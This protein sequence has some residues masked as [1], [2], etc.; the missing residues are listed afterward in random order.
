MKL[1]YLANARIPTEKAHGYQICKMCEEF[2]SLGNQVELW[3]PARKNDIY[4]DA[5]SFYGLKNNFKVKEINS[6]DF[7]KHYK[8]L[9]RLSFWLQLFCFSLKLLFIKIDRQAVIYTRDSEIGW[10]FNLKGNKVILE[11][12]NWPLSKGWLFKYLI[13]KFDKIITITRGLK[14][15]FLAA[16]LP[17]SRIMVAPD[18][19]D[20]EKFNVNINKIQARKKL[21][22]PLNKKIALYCGSLYL[23]SWKGVDILLAAAKIFPE[24]YLVVLVGGEP[25]ELAKIKKESNGN[26]LLLVG[27][28]PREEIPY[29]LKSADVL[30]LPNS[31]KEKISSSYTSPLKLFEYMA[32]QRPIV[33]S[34]LPSIREILNENNS[35][36]VE[37]G[38]TKSLADGIKKV[39]SDKEL[40]DK[41]SR[42]AYQDVQRYVWEKRAKN[43]INYIK[44]D[45]V[46]NL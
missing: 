12:H 33:A 10:I 26:N 19:V 44:K 31:G 1:Y 38:K 39:L 21:N 3:I 45:N 43:I 22:L 41:I 16:G 8:Y 9:G 6:F 34:N 14:E 25:N 27:R 13:K 40:G 36:M 18:G 35:I 11:S 24:D 7:N 37:S 46:G 30:V 23:Y 28:Q 29:Y 20:L 42:Q 4:K 15:L 2:S 32:S 17:D 5:Y